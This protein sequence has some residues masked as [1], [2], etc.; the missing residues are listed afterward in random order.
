MSFG[1]R[2]QERRHGENAGEAALTL[3]CIPHAVFLL[4]KDVHGLN[5][6]IMQKSSQRDTSFV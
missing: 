6:Q 3:R 2:R 1:A 5:K 4:G